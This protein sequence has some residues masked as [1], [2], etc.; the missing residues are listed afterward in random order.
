MEHNGLKYGVPITRAGGLAAGVNEHDDS[1]TRLSESLV[2]V[3]DLWSL[4]EFYFLRDE[5]RW[6]VTPSQ[7]GVAGELARV[8]IFN[9]IGSGFLV[10]VE[11]VELLPLA[12]VANFREAAG[13]T[14]PFLPFDATGNP[15]PT[16]SRVE[17]FPL[18]TAL[19]T[20]TFS[21]SRVGTIGSLFGFHQ[22]AANG[23]SKQ[24]PVNIVLTPGTFWCIEQV[25]V[26]TGIQMTIRG[27]ERKAFKGEIEG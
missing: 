17:N 13:I 4:P 24:T 10:V 8:G 20:G 5:R 11:T 15:S 21:D 16:D 14:A 1:I 6:S 26:N 2:S 22:T 7:S 25:I 9:P 3:L 23:D 18:N 27:R 12:A 19:V